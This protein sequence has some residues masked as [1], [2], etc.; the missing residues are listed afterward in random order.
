MDELVQTF[1]Y[2][3]SSCLDGTK[4]FYGAVGHGTT[5]KQQQQQTSRSRPQQ[6]QWLWKTR[7]LY[8]QYSQS[9]KK[10]ATVTT[11]ANCLRTLASYQVPSSKMKTMGK[12]CEL[13]TLKVL[14]NLCC[15][16]PKFHGS[17]LLSSNA[18]IH[19]S[20]VTTSSSRY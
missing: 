17:S 15:S 2:L 13:A 19:C 16:S 12:F 5:T 3:H 1:Q 4:C 6:Q 20:L 8:S 18:F 10:A 11:H 7:W 14:Q 9:S